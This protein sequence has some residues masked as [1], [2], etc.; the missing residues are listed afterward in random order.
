MT[1]TKKDMKGKISKRK[2]VSKKKGTGWK[3]YS[4]GPERTKWE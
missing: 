4:F 3:T 2:P 1:K